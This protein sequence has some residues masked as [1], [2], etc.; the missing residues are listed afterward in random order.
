MPR[1]YSRR[2]TGVRPRRRAGK[3]SISTLK[4]RITK[5]E[6]MS[7]PERKRYDT[8]DQEDTFGQVN[9]N[10]A[11]YH[12]V[13]TT[14]NPAQ[15][16]GLNQRIGSAIRVTGTHYNFQIRQMSAATGNARVIVELYAIPGIVWGNVNTFTDTIF[17]SNS[18]LRS[19]GG[20]AGIV[21]YN[22]DYD[23]DYFQQWKLL[24]R[25]RVYIRA[26]SLASQTNVVSFSM[27]VK[28]RKPH[29]IKWND[30][31]TT[32]VQGQIIMVVR[33]DTGNASTGTVSTITGIANSAVSTGYVLNYNHKS[34]YI[35]D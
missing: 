12:A 8:W 29:K 9:G 31:G 19:G 15:G 25:K 16:V 2:R 13:D 28:F 26:D 18:F 6:R 32:V 7:K 17:E 21:D 3:T 4:K 11:A 23:P 27:G 5:V 1:K 24:R 33:A 14:P 35:D 10:N 20:G 34:Y 22:S 30:N